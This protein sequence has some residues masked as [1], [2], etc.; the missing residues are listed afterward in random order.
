MVLVGEV[1]ALSR[2]PLPQSNSEYLADSDHWKSQNLTALMAEDEGSTVSMQSVKDLP[3]VDAAKNLPKAATKELPGPTQPNPS[4]NDA[5][6]TAQSNHSTKEGS[7]S[8][9]TLP[10]DSAYQAPSSLPSVPKSVGGNGGGVFVTGHQTI[11]D[12][13]E[14]W[15]EPERFDNSI[16]RK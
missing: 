12:L 13:L 6:G 8:A 14:R 7:H 10:T 4:N 2:E 15:E 1:A 9:R 16:V 5:G 11:M 3:D